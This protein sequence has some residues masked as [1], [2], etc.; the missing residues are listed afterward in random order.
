[1]KRNETKQQQQQQKNIYISFFKIKMI[2]K[3]VV[4]VIDEYA[5]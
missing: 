2:K 4:H 1:M 5:P 3:I